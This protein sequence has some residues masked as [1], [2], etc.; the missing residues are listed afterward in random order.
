[1]LEFNV[2]IFEEDLNY[3][4]NH[5]I[6]TMQCHSTF[7]P[8]NGQ[9]ALYFY[10]A[11][12]VTLKLSVFS[13]KT[14][15]YH[16]CVL[17]WVKYRQPCSVLSCINRYYFGDCGI[18]LNFMKLWSIRCVAREKIVLFPLGKCNSNSNIFNWIKWM[19]AE[20]SPKSNVAMVE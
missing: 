14:E 10:C 13:E 1:M 7:S 16:D 12:I 2:F 19:E 8:S 15:F 4:W 20:S 5:K 9:I 18:T 11:N 3:F 6:N 17:F